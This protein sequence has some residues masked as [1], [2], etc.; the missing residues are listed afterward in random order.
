MSAT[1]TTKTIKV[2]AKL[3]PM[4]AKIFFALSGYAQEAVERA[5]RPPPFSTS[6]QFNSSSSALGLSVEGTDTLGSAQPPPPAELDVML[7][8]VC[9][10]LVLVTQCIVTI[11]LEADEQRSNQDQNTTLAT[12]EP[13]LKEFFIETRSSDRGI[14]ASL[15]GKFI[16]PTL[17]DLSCHP[18]QNSSVCSICFCPELILESQ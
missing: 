9:E 3:S 18:I 5:L 8:K 15:I 2:H 14:V 12:P 11:A 6:D 4:L 7:P 13:D 10:A 17:A 1:T 16:A